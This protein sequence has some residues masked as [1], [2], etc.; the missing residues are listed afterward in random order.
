MAAEEWKAHP[1]RAWFPG[2]WFLQGN[3]QPG[4]KN[5]GGWV[6]FCRPAPMPV[7]ELGPVVGTE[8]EIIASARLIAA[9]PELYEALRLCA[10]VI[11]GDT[12]HKQGLV[13]ALEAAQAAMAAA[14][15]DKKAPRA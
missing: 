12:M 1:Q 9:A 4:S 2:P 7:F 3:W 5:I 8:Q 10:A 11:A 6:S 13:E 14:T 15:G